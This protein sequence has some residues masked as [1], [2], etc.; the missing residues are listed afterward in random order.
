MQAKAPRRAPAT[1]PSEAGRPKREANTARTVLT[2]TVRAARAGGMPFPTWEF[3][4]EGDS[5]D[6]ESAGSDEVDGDDSD[7][8]GMSHDGDHVQ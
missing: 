3:D 1:P 6:G 7:L 4:D 8:G 5:E 2:L